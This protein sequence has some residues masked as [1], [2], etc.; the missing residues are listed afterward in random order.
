MWVRVYVWDCVCARGARACVCVRVR[1]NPRLLRVV[2]SSLSHLI[3]RNSVA[4]L[5]LW[6]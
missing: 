6:C 1:V 5:W 4:E 3:V 2:S